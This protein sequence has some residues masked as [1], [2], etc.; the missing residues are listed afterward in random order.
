MEFAEYQGR[1]GSTNQLPPGGPHNAVA[2]VLGLGAEAGSILNVYK[3]HLR[4]NIDLD[5]NVELLEEELG[6]L[7]WYVATVASSFGLELE[8]IAQHNLIRT[9]DFFGTPEHRDRAWNDLP[10][11]DDAYPEHERFPRR[12]L[13]SFQE[14]GD[15]S[16]TRISS[17]RILGAEPN[18]FTGGPMTIGGKAQGFEVP[19]QLGDR[20]TDNS[21]RADGYRF[22]DAIHLGFAAVLGWSPQTRQM[23]RLKRRSNSVTDEAEDGARA[24]F[25]EEGLAAILARLAVRRV[26][27]VSETS[28]DME[29]VD[30]AR[31]ITADLEC[32]EL[33]AWLWRRAISQGFSAMNSLH[34]H[35]GGVLVADLNARSL[36]FQASRGQAGIYS[37]GVVTA[38]SL[39]SA[40][41]RLHT[42]KDAVYRDAWKK[43]GEVLGVIANI[44][45][46]ADRLENVLDGATP[47]ADES[48]L[49]TVVDLFVYA[50]KYEAFLADSSPDVDS[51]LFPGA[52]RGVGGRSD[53]TD[54]INRLLWR[55]AEAGSP[56]SDS[57]EVVGA[58][59]LAAFSNLEQSFGDGGWDPPQQRLERARDLARLAWKLLM[60]LCTDNPAEG[61][62]FVQEHGDA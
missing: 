8:S 36:T 49:D 24:I 54:W 43:R 4:D 59:V 19:M 40:V 44:A 51:V 60:A 2:P 25:A 29:T 3:R 46:K 57:V 32:A 7:L 34:A 50:V 39:V 53:G 61:T 26:G 20:L 1:A 52:P 42:A 10:I 21:R 37:V 11:F 35:H 18:V 17:L 23:L 58:E 6:D 12:M 30:L 28:V 55:H 16:G 27:F 15:D 48:L 22:H 5:A 13:F 38:E 62:K 31:A 33:P 45:R 56:A 41:C 47:T 9:G 14:L